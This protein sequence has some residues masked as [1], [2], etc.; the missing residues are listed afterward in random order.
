MWTTRAASAP[1][2][3]P[4]CSRRP[5]SSLRRIC[6]G[7]R[8]SWP[9]RSRY[10]SPASKSPRQPPHA[11]LHTLGALYHK[12]AGDAKRMP[13]VEEAVCRSAD[14]RL[15]EAGRALRRRDPRREVRIRRQ[16]ARCHQ[17]DA[18]SEPA[19]RRAQPG[20][21]GESG[22]E[23]LHVVVEDC[24]AKRMKG[25][26]GGGE[27]W[28]AVLRRGRCEGPVGIARRGLVAEGHGLT[29]LMFQALMLSSRNRAACTVRG[30]AAAGPMDRPITE[31][32]VASS[33]NT[34]LMDRDQL[35][36]HSSA[37][38]YARL[39]L[40][41]CRSVELDCWD[42]ADGEPIITHGKTSAPPSASRASP[43]P[44]RTRPLSRYMGTPRSRS[45]FPRRRYNRQPRPLFRPPT[46]SPTVSHH[47]LAC[48]SLPICAQSSLPPL[49][50]MHCSR[51]QQ[52]RIADILID[53]LGDLLLTAEEAE[54][55]AREHLRA[56]WARSR[57]RLC[58]IR[59]SS[60]VRSRW[61]S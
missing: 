33:H 52:R 21:W 57:R 37:N 42:G 43:W 60:R 23:A 20:L 47:L 19:L 53:E 4:S 34:Y 29:P 51:P 48:S 49:L 7:R 56:V 5:T 17:S 44:L 28:R 12:Y 39:L 61:A 40:Q 3:C 6:C 59:S 27:A 15:P 9:R 58:G 11:V 10:A 22:R 38:I 13:A 2:A 46:S 32:W 54:D 45:L 41:G 26:R 36:G 14:W 16:A 30:A 1:S 55:L 50:E 24:D 8:S 35:A 18:Y 25:R 31:Y